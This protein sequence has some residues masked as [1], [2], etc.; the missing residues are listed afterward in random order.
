MRSGNSDPIRAEIRPQDVPRRPL[1]WSLVLP[2][3]LAA[4]APC[5]Q[6]QEPASKE[7]E[8][9]LPEIVVT[10]THQEAEAFFIPY[11]T[12]VLGEDRLQK[13]KI[14]RTVPEALREMPSVS[15]QKTAHGQGSP[16][17][18]GFTG[19]RTLFLVDGIRLNHSVFREGPNQYW[20][21]VDPFLIERLEIVRGP[22]SVLYGSDAIGGAVHAT[23]RSEVFPG[24]PEE[25][26]QRLYYR[27]GSAEDAHVL[28][29][30]VGGP[31]GDLR[32]LIGSSWKDFG[33]VDAGRHVG[34]QPNTGYQEGS[35]DF[36]LV[37]PLGDLQ[38]VLA[39]QHTSQV[40]VPRTHRTVF[41]QSYRGTT[42]GT[43]RQQDIDHE[44]DLSYVQLRWKDEFHGRPSEGLLSISHQLQR[45]RDDR[46]RGSGARNLQG[47]SVATWGAA[48]QFRFG[49]LAYGLDYTHDRVGSFRKDF[50]AAGALTAKRIQGPVGDDASYDLAGV[51]FQDVIALGPQW[52][53]LPGV[54]Y[55]Y[56]AV[57][58]DDV[59][60][61]VTGGETAVDDSWRR[62]AGS[63]RILFRA[64]ERWNLFGGV[65]QGFRTP[66]L[67]DLTRFDFARSNEVETPS[68]DLDPEEFLGYELGAKAKYD[69]WS[70][71]GAIFYTQVQDMIV[72]FPTGALIGSDAEVRK[73][74]V[75]DGF[76]EGIEF[77]GRY[78]LTDWWSL[79]GGFGWLV[80]KV[81][82]FPTSAQIEE[83]KTIDRMPPAAGFA[84]VRWAEPEGKYW[85]ELVATMARHQR[86][87]SPGDVADTQRIPPGGT[88]GYTVAT[89]RGG[90][91]ATDR[92]TLSGAVENLTNKDYRVHG[93]GQNEAGTNFVIAMEARF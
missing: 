83:R 6:A 11:S 49:G 89:L 15:V 13:E 92:I 79:I 7:T 69:R 91:K 39:H 48:A 40:D 78:W 24:A 56:A 88:P 19:F 65:S 73:A 51:Y 34:R 33:D 77:D 85:A 75:G 76:V 26:A 10:A 66:N 61:P 50:N 68:P 84:G 31:A 93:S 64:T 52:E 70:L 17:L 38:A 81:D 2:C 45:E 30:E 14:S 28:R 12:T 57:D 9:R 67:S 44:R 63:L 32:Y 60:D 18:R 25:H 87:L 41:S 35:G 54:R 72:K 42:V 23:T 90:L 47:F 80:G 71:A 22:A 20:N 5:L 58:A 55:T 16:F 3:I 82:Q 37:Y 4:T 43:D 59:E 36:K 53:I 29:A 46:I 21:T 8:P 86:R 62:L 27:F 74:N 1:G